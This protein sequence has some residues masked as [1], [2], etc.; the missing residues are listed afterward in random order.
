MIRL[1]SP[2]RATKVLER[3][4]GWIEDVARRYDMPS[5]LVKAVLYQE[6]TQMDVLDPVADV[7]VQI[8]PRYSRDSSTG[9]AQIFGR[10][11]LAAVNFAVDRGLAT[12]ESLGIDAVHRLDAKSARDVHKVW[13]KLHRDKQT[14]IEIAALVLLMISDEVVGRTDFE[15]FT[16]DELKLVF[17]RYNADV[18]YI[19]SYGEQV[20]DHYERFRGE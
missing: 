8:A 18:D 15:S 13:L 20:F 19:T 14:N 17:T 10:T 2:K 1:M 3:Y 9:Y 6:M 5:A 12:Y 11:G 16:D 7:A 4:D